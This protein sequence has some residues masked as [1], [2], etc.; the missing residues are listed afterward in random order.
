MP[1]AALPHMAR[2]SLVLPPLNREQA[3]DFLKTK[4]MSYAVD[5]KAYDKYFRQF[6]QQRVYVATEEERAAD[7]AAS[8]W[9]G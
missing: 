7:T 8:R 3:M 5:K 4:D 6:S 9:A 1:C 2:P